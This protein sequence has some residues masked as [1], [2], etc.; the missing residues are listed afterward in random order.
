M[1]N[2]NDKLPTLIDVFIE[3]Q[4]IIAKK[5]LKQNNKKKFTFDEYGVPLEVIQNIVGCNSLN[6]LKKY[7]NK[8]KKIY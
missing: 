2:K 4:I 6:D 1:S 8:F 5:Q 3:R 7:F